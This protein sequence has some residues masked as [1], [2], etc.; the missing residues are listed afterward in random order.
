M[1]HSCF[2]SYKLRPSSIM[3]ALIPY[4]ISPIIVFNLWTTI[5]VKKHFPCALVKSNNV[6]ENW[7][8]SPVWNFQIL[9]CCTIYM[10]KQPFSTYHCD[11]NL[12][13]YNS[14]CV[15]FWFVYLQGPCSPSLRLKWTVFIRIF[16]YCVS[17]LFPS[18]IRHRHFLMCLRKY[19]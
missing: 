3:S 2:I 1:C 10:C 5:S 8:P 4:I 11:K 19:E 15:Y 9:K 13:C 17:Y 14:K 12:P 16:L 6:P 7:Y 18:K